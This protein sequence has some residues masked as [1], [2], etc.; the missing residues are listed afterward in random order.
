MLETIA[1]EALLKS[2]ITRGPCRGAFRTEGVRD[3]Y[4][5]IYSRD[6]TR[7]AMAHDAL[8][9][10][11]GVEQHYDVMARLQFFSGEFVQRY[12][13]EG[14]AAVTR[15]K[16]T[17]ATAMVLCGMCSHYLLTKNKSFIRRMLPSMLL[18]AKY[19]QGMIKENGLAY[20]IHAVHENQEVEKGF[21]IWTNSWTCRAFQLFGKVM[22]DLNKKSL[23]SKFEERHRQLLDNILD[24]MW[25]GKHFIKVIKPNG[26]IIDGRLISIIA[27]AWAEIIPDDS[28]EMRKTVGYLKPLWDSKIGGYQRF[29][30]FEF[31]KDWH[32]YDGGSGSWLN[33]TIMM[34]RLH[35]KLR[36][37]ERAKECLRF[38]KKALKNFNTLPEHIATVEEFHE[39]KK[40]EYASRVHV[41][42]W[43]IKATKKAEKSMEEWTWKHKKTCIVPWVK[44]LFWPDAE[45]I[46]N[47]PVFK[48][49][50]KKC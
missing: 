4:P 7:I 19:L 15:P 6:S 37:Y 3:R 12:D 43:L 22:K 24:K 1:K 38:V 45:L 26:Q 16:E 33:H 9:K 41:T 25:N 28:P 11:V 44:S 29:R 23:A 42:P 50:W 40:Y 20:G 36:Q 21:E 46:L 10:Y 34:A 8:G 31:V 17:D 35:T 5:F 30:K 49:V 39:W 2:R 18:S 48:E 13:Y 47:M 32:W 27:P 14:R